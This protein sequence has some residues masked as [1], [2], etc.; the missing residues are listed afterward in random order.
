MAK[1]IPIF[2]FAHQLGVFPFPPTKVENDT[3]EITCNKLEVAI[4]RSG[5]FSI[6]Q[7]VP[8]L[9]LA[10]LHFKSTVKNRM[11]SI[12]KAPFAESWWSAVFRERVSNRVM[13]GE[14]S[15][16]QSQDGF[17]VS[18]TIRIKAAT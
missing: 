5:I 2:C 9:L 15:A 12:S 13:W 10:C 18:N 17:R 8:Y 3:R 1:W 6:L 14:R 7:A 11:T 16:N 4:K